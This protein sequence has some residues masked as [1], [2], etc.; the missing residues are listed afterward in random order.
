MIPLYHFFVKLQLIYVYSQE[1]IENE[2]K[3]L[4]NQFYDVYL[5]EM[6]L[7]IDKLNLQKKEEVSEVNN[8]YYKDF[9]KMIINKD[10]YIVNHPKKWEN[11]FKIL[12]KKYD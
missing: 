8:I 9:E 2:S 1:V 10:K 6:D 11:L 5:V 3:F 4:D 7:D 12:H